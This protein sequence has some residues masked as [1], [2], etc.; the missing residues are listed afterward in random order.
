VPSSQALPGFLIT[1]SPS[2]CVPDAIGMLAVWIQNQK[3]KK[4]PS[5]TD[6]PSMT[7]GRV[8]QEDLGTM[9]LLQGVAMEE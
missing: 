1:A 7:A 4:N 5:R 9:R 3:K 2:V 6:V 8:L